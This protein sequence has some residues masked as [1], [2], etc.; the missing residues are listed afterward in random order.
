[1]GGPR[2]RR[3]EKPIQ[4]ISSTGLLFL[5]SHVSFFMPVPPPFFENVFSLLVLHP[6]FDVEKLILEAHRRGDLSQVV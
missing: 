3:V 5:W 2:W 4:C 6:M 1:M